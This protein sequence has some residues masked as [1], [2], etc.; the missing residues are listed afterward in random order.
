MNPFLIGLKLKVVTNGKYFRVHA[1]VPLLP[2]WYDAGFPTYDTFEQAAAIA[3]RHS[4]DGY[5][6]CQPKGK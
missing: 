1:K 5:K 4:E 6:D 2:I 3:D